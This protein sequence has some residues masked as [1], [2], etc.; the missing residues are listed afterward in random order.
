MT[1]SELICNTNSYPILL[2]CFVLCFLTLQLRLCQATRRDV[3]DVRMGREKEKKSR[4][5]EVGVKTG[6]VRCRTCL[7][8]ANSPPEQ[9][10]GW[11]DSIYNCSDCAL[12]WLLIALPYN[13]LQLYLLQRYLSAYIASCWCSSKPKLNREKALLYFH[14]P[15]RITRSLMSFFP[16]KQVRYIVVFPL[17]LKL[18]L[19]LYYILLRLLQRFIKSSYYIMHQIN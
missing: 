14:T 10:G 4:T 19:C 1:G 17:C 5:N 3:R 8:T 12:V 18:Q 13:W 7:H 9:G 6:H 15:L 16:Y 2:D 11:T